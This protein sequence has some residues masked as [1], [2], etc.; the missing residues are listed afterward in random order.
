MGDWRVKKLEMVR[1]EAI[2]L[3]DGCPP[4]WITAGKEI[5]GKPPLP[6]NTSA[7]MQK[8]ESDTLFRDFPE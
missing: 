6:E 7:E 4:A 1:S 2:T 3:E 8:Q 5:C